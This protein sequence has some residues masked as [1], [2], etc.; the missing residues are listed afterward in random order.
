MRT[1][2]KILVDQLI[3]QGTN[4]VFCVPGESYLEILNA[5]HDVN[6][7]VKVYNARHEAG[8]ANMAEA[9]GKLTGSPGIALVTRGPGA[10]HAS[11]G[12]HIAY[13]DSTPMILIIG[14][15]SQG[16]RDRESFQEIDYQAMFGSISKWCAEIDRVERI[17]EYIAKAYN[18][19]TSGRTG[20]VVLSI[21]ENVLIQRV[22]ITDLYPTQRFAAAPERNVDEMLANFFADAQKPLI[23]LGGPGWSEEASTNVLLFATK[24]SIPV[25]VG[26]RRQDIFDNNSQVFCGALGTAVSSSLLQ[27][28]KAA[29]LLLVIGSRLGDITTQGYKI[30]S[31]SNKKQKFIHVH[32]DPSEIGS[33]FSPDL[34]VVSTSCNFSKVLS[35]VCLYQKTSWS[36][37]C[38]LLHSEHLSD[39]KYPIYSGPL[40]LG[41]IA[42]ELNC[43]LPDNTIVTL[44]AG[45]HTGWPQRFLS[46]SPLRR[47]IGSTC[48]A[49]G[50]SVPAAV[51]S[52][53]TFPKRQVI[54]FVGDGGFMM[55][56]MELMTAVQHAVSLIIIVFNNNSYGTIRMHQEREHP[57]RV[58]ATDLQNPNFKAMAI[59]MG[60]HGE[61]VKKTD[62]FL[63]ALQRCLS[64]K[65]PALIELKTD[66][67]QLSTRFNLQDM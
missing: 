37:W 19:A 22:E 63:P 3:C 14:Q 58:I 31:E 11:V 27:R 12:V 66:L 45:N 35:N 1:G 33:V 18:L 39:S 34:G 53:V 13:Q 8:A 64:Q 25:V 20:P 29:D 17:P 62:E 55:S 41:K 65:K 46:Y 44:D 60:A 26:F 23:I 67:N 38:K 52:A 56:G 54:C 4:K 15:V 5:L 40:D 30:F 16:T 43:C 10:C 59:S 42:T 57:G 24:H 6:D 61:L 7:I 48:G 36:D 49:M 21:P 9:Y 50:Y 28:I 32:V 51:A 47:Q 2:G